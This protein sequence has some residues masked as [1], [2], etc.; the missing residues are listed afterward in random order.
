VF[1]THPP[2][3]LSKTLSRTHSARVLP[4]ASFFVPNSPFREIMN[5]CC[6]VWGYDEHPAKIAG[7][8]A[9]YSKSLY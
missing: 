5:I 7:H 2:K 8:F 3:N 9:L 4:G 6:V 1:S